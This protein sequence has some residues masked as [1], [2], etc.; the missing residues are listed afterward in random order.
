MKPSHLSRQNGVVIVITLIVLVAM[1]LTAILLYRKVDIAVLIAGNIAFKQGTSMT[2]DRG[3]ESA[4]TWL[5]ANSGIAL[6]ANQSIGA[7]YSATSKN[8]YYA[9][10]PYNSN[11]ALRIDFHGRDTSTANNFDWT[12]A[13][14]LPAA[15]AS[16]PYVISYVIHRLCD[17]PGKPTA[18][19]CQRSSIGGATASTKGTPSYGGYALATAT[20]VHYQ[21]TV[22]VTGPRNSVSYI[23]AI[24]N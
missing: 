17:A 23:Q 10:F 2:G 14:T 9:S 18:V 6:E 20:Q 19:S 13:A 16:D 1:S 21:V 8:A 11:P 12:T 24:L 4:R 22:R 5:N 15:S 7:P 3:I